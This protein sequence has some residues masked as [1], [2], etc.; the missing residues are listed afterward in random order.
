MTEDMKNRTAELEKR[1]N[2]T[3]GWRRR[4]EQA[5]ARQ[6][7][8]GNELDAAPDVA[9]GLLP[10]TERAAAALKDILDGMAQQPSQALRLVVDISL[11]LDIAR[12]GDQV[13]SRLEGDV[14]LI[15][16]PLPESLKDVVLDVGETPTGT[17]LVLTPLAP[18]RPARV[19]PNEPVQQADLVRS[20][21]GLRP[22]ARG[23]SPRARR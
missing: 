1:T 23:S 14:L 10:V 15:E 22:G 2:E 18:Q 19:V 5:S 7:S 21:R 13:V 17:S 8:A 4:L 11:A 20:G 12:E 6:D 9:A 16:S 3:Q